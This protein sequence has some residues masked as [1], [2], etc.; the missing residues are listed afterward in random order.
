MSFEGLH[1]IFNGGLLQ[2]LLD[3]LLT[4]LAIMIPTL[5][6]EAL[7]LVN[8]LGDRTLHLHIGLPSLLTL[9]EGTVRRFNRP[10]S[11]RVLDKLRVLLLFV[12]GVPLLDL[13]LPDV[14]LVLLHVELIFEIALTVRIV[15]LDLVFEFFALP[16]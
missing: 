9:Y 11:M 4:A 2:V 10:L 15:L 5:Q 13:L 7:L 8:L 6:P 1:L 14:A 3:H 16:D 12:F